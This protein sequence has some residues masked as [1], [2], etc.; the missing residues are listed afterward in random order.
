MSGS[1]D[2]DFESD[3]EDDDLI[4]KPKPKKIPKRSTAI[5][6]LMDAANSKEELHS[7]MDEMQSMLGKEEKQTTNWIREW[8]EKSK[9]PQTYGD[10]IGMRDLMGILKE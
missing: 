10:N 5:Q 4:P 2:I 1:T 6:I 8:F 9:V 7:F 3:G